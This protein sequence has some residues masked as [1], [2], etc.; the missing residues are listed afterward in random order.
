MRAALLP[1]CEAPT[2]PQGPLRRWD[3][4]APLGTS[5]LG[6]LLFPPHARLGPLR[7]VAMPRARSAR[8]G[9]SM[10]P[11]APR[12]HQRAP[13]VVL[14]CRWGRFAPREQQ[15]KPQRKHA[16]RATCAPVASQPRRPVPGARGL[17]PAL[18]HAQPAP[19]ACTIPC[20]RPLQS[21]HAYHARCRSQRGPTA[22]LARC[23]PPRVHRVQLATR[24]LAAAPSLCRVRR[25]PLLPAG[26]LPACR[27]LRGRARM[28]GAALAWT[29]ASR[30]T[31]LHREAIAPQGFQPQPA[32]AAALVLAA[33]QPQCSA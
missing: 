3:C 20:P 19:T 1:C 15:R 32:L 27:A 11:L 5:A 14:L 25:T 12:R 33:R 24:V 30:A 16:Q 29:L 7:A 2:A 31:P 6:G 9:H 21:L 18:A 13:L 28:P 23:R 8:W 26:L 10:P 4:L 22:Q 17:L